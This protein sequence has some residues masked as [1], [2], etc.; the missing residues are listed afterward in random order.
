MTKK[1]GVILLNLGGPDSLK[2]VR[3]FLYNL[4]S[5]RDIIRLGPAPL[6][7]PLAFLISLLRS[8]KSK[9]AYRLIGGFSPLRTIT[10]AQASSLREKLRPNRI[11]VYTGM[12]YW[13]PF[14]EDTVEEIKQDRITHLIGL[15]LYPHYSIATSGS[16][17]KR[18]EEVLRGTGIYLK[19]IKSWPDNPLYIRALK[20]N[21]LK[22]LNITE[23]P[24]RAH[25]LFSAHSLPVSFVEKGDPYV[26]ELLKTIKALSSELKLPWHLSYQSRSGPV[27]WLS[28]STEE[29]LRELA[30]HSVKEVIIVPI[31]FVSDHIETLYEIDIYYKE[32][33]SML[34]I[35][36]YRTESLNTNPLFIEALYNMVINSLEESGWKGL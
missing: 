20:E 33:A 24:E 19:L 2:S 14:I 10:E 1:I 34:G 36:L 22:T 27:K 26:E 6:Q 15:C 28:P 11:S 18:L 13:H 3:P 25:L 4:F 12:R 5:D 16:A 31:S 29:K 30:L 35:K 8:K 9:D 17:I 23:E 21:I 32:I 7:K